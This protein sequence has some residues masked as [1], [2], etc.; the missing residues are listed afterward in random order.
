M[1]R[2]TAASA[3]LYPYEQTTMAITPGAPSSTTA[4]RPSFLSDYSTPILALGAAA[5]LSLSAYVIYSHYSKPKPTRTSP[6]PQ[7]PS[8]SNPPP[9]SSLPPLHP[10]SSPYPSPLPT[11]TSILLGSRTSQLAM[12]QAQHVA[13]L[14]TSLHPSPLAFPIVGL[15]TTGD[16]DQLKPLTDFA[17]KGVFTKELDIALLTSRIDAAVHCVKDL[18]TTLPPG[19]TLAAILPRGDLEDALILPSHSSLPS[20]HSLSSLPPGAIIGTSAMRRKA[21]LARSHPHL[22]CRDIRGNV[23]TRLAKLDRG[24]YDA[25]VL[26]AVGLRR[27]GL[28]HRISQVMDKGTYGYAV[29]QGALGVVAREG[30]ASCSTARGGG[31]KG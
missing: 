29:G 2:T 23:N 28:G 16:L 3:L 25:I 19:L 26:A 22:Q 20:P 1:Q 18:P 13:V 14:L 8:T 7:P 5:A 6:P 10:S 12:W 31:K 11:R 4:S 15:N 27:L 30:S 17:N 21:S 9:P 24:D